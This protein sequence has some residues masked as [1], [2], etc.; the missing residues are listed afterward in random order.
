MAGV[1][2][3]IGIGNLTKDPEIKYATSGA[4]IANFSV[5]CNESWKNKDGT[6][7]EKV[8]FISIV[9]FSK[10]AEIC[11]QFLVRGKQVYVEGRIQTREWEDKSGNKRYTTEIIASQVQFLGAKNDTPKEEVEPAVDKKVE[12]DIEEEDLPF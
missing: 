4:A 11:G 10:L 3:W 8:E 1:N 5:A 9:A 12:E 2:K 6:K 7:E